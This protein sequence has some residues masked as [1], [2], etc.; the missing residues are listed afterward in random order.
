[1]QFILFTLLS[2]PPNFWWQD[3]LERRFPG[4]IT[5]SSSS[6]SSSDVTI[7]EK[8]DSSTIAAGRDGEK[9]ETKKLHVRNTLIKLV[10]DQSVG[11]AVN[12]IAFIAT[13]GSL[14]GQSRGEVFEAVA[15]VST[16]SLLSI[17]PLYCTFLFMLPLSPCS[18]HH[19]S[20]NPSIV[21]G[22]SLAIHPFVPALPDMELDASIQ[23][24]FILLAS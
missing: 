24:Q 15:R 7:N 22:I 8:Q 4:Y 20:C 21:D 3:Y 14:R 19:H 9:R 23:F 10:L 18:F 2:C 11:A 12:T 17:Y 1:M 13:M 16:A 6:L 5:T